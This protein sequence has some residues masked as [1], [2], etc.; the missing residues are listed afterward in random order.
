MRLAT[1]GGMFPA[2]LD[3]RDPEAVRGSNRVRAFDRN[4]VIGL[5]TRRW[6]YQ[7]WGPSISAGGWVP[8]A[9]VTDDY[10]QPL[11]GS[12]LVWDSVLLMVQRAREG[13]EAAC[14]RV[15]AHNERLRAS[16]LADMQAD[17][18]ERTAYCAKAIGREVNGDGRYS[19]ED[20]VRGLN[21]RWL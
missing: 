9:D 4:M 8:I 10:G 2:W 15:H 16:R 6:V 7:L 11:R 21:S 17:R 14:D 20:M 3:T 5:D 19:A 12:G 1:P 13:A 18:R